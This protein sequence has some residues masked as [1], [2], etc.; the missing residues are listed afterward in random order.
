M[1]LFEISLDVKL[2]ASFVPMWIIMVYKVFGVHDDWNH[3]Q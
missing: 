3:P 2:V 1:G